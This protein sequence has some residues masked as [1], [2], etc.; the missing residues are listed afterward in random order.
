MPHHTFVYNGAE[1]REKNPA[2][3]VTAAPDQ[4]ELGANPPADGGMTPAEVVERAF[5][6]L[7][8]ARHLGFR[9]LWDL[10]EDSGFLYPEKMERLLHEYTCSA[11]SGI[12]GK[13]RGTDDAL[14]P[15]C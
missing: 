10:Y 3:S 13:E 5:P 15:R 9:E 14:T 12:F 1:I 6:G 2:S 7:E 4:P 11:Q 8:V